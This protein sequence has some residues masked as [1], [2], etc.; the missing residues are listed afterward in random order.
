M[1]TFL[2]PSLPPSFPPSDK[3]R[4]PRHPQFNPIS[5]FMI[6]PLFFPQRRH[7]VQQITPS[8]PLSSPFFP[9]HL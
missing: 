8:F 5:Y 1:K 7:Q 3:G 2:P 9:P 6:A 4:L